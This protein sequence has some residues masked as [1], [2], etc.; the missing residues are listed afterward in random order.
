MQQSSAPISQVI[1]NSPPPLISKWILNQWTVSASQHGHQTGHGSR[2]PGGGGGV[3]ALAD[4]LIHP[5]HV[6]KEIY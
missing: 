3:E 5:D 4:P 2:T 1:L 6:E